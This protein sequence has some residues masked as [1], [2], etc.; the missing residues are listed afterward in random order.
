MIA[1]VLAILQNLPALLG[2]LSE[3]I[4]L[5]G[6]AQDSVIASARINQLT[7]AIKKARETKDTSDIENFFSGHSS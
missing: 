3:A 4:K 7:G 2:L 5:I 6:E 1:A